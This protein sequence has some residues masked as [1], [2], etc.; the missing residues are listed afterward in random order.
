MQYLLF[1]R[2]DQCTA[3]AVDELLSAV[4]PQRREEALHIRHL[5]GRFAAL[6]SFQ[7]LQQLLPDLDW[8][9]TVYRRTEHGK[10]YLC[11]R[12]GNPLPDVYFSISHCARG[13]LVAVSEQPIGVDIESFR[14]FSDSLLRRCMNEQE[15]RQILQSVNPQREFAQ[16][17]T[18]KEAVCKLR[19]TGLTDDLPDLLSGSETTKTYCNPAAGYAYSFA[20]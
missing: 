3:A 4:P 8:R 19:G 11:G 16:L 13:L 12:D 9:N 15:Q 2:M 17:W 18:C 1:D 10:P 7:L 20:W 6:K 14:H 5:S